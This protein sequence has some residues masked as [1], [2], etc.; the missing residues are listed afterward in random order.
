VGQAN[1]VGA[2]TFLDAFAQFRNNMGLIA[3][4][5]DIG[6]VADMGYAARDK[7]LLQRLI[8]NGYSGVTQAGRDDRGV[9][10]HQ[11]VPSDHVERQYGKR[12][13]RA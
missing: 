12:T 11:L 3:S 13:I 5:I 7:T 6:A 1:Y 4:S 8:T 9:H 2:N 10:G